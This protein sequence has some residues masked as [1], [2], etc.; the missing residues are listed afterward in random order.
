M[1]ACRICQDQY[2]DLAKTVQDRKF[3]DGRTTTQWKPFLEGTE[4]DR[5]AWMCYWNAS[6]RMA[7]RNPST[8]EFRNDPTLAFQNNMAGGVVSSR[9]ILFYSTET[10]CQPDAFLIQQKNSEWRV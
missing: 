10:C 7:E 1:K 6:G 9:G 8:S 2:G 4:T 5:E 3:D